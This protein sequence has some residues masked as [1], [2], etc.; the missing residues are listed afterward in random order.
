MK[1]KEEFDQWDSKTGWFCQKCPAAIQYIGQK[2]EFCCGE[3]M[4]LV[5]GGKQNHVKREKLERKKGMEE[6]K[7]FVDGGCSFYGQNAH[8][9]ANE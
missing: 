5:I 7:R 8:S 3:K 1:V 9:V 6:K 2:E 4:R